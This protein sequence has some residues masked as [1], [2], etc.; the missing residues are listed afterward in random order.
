MS[1]E[2][3]QVVAMV[4]RTVDDEEL[5]AF[6]EGVRAGLSKKL[7]KQMSSGMKYV[8]AAKQGLE[9]GFVPDILHPAYPIVPKT[10]AASIPRLSI[11]WL[12]K[13]FGGWGTDALFGLPAEPWP[14]YARERW[15]RLRSRQG[16]TAGSGTRT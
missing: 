12:T 11:V 10:K 15:S 9:M 16:C 14:S 6:V 7:P 3:Q 8:V 13:K 4:G 1:I 2:L 5:R